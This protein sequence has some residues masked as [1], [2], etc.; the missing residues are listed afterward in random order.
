MERDIM[1]KVRHND[2]EIIEYRIKNEYLEMRFLNIGGVIT[3]IAL[4]E[5]NYEKNLVLNYENIEDYL[6][7]GCYLNAIVGRTANRI[8]NGKFML[9]GREMQ[10]DLN[11]GPNNLHGG[12]ENLSHTFFAVEAFG[13][14]YA[15]T[16]I[17]PHQPNGFPGEL[18][19][20][21]FYAL[22]GNRVVINYEAQTTE[23]TIFNPTQH[24]YFNL[25]GNLERTINDHILL[26][27][28]K[29][30]ANI[31]EASSFTEE[32]TAV[33]GT[34]FDFTTPTVIEPTGKPESVL[35][36]LA[37]GYDH[38][39]VLD[40]TDHAATFYDPTSKRRLDVLTTEKSMQFYA[41]NYL[42]ETLTFEGGRKG[43]KNLGACFETHQ[44][45]FNFQALTLKPG[46]VYSQ[47][48]TWI[49]TAN[50]EAPLE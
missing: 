30:V 28:G 36:D 44:V 45:P 32:F 39:Y 14:G 20:K 13:D 27:N 5:D 35:F 47:T 26:I 7:N 1:R 42:D 22:K 49:F 25:S 16:T 31:N 2:Q 50:A 8:T 24:A 33:T 4:A 15:L 19:I 40:D 17:L 10:V 41:G 11:D 46:D 37:T 18:K 21:V 48:A 6:D 12:A 38:L 23:T 9:E 34:R 43:E 29:K 3:K